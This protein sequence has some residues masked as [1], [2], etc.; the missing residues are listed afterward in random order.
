MTTRRVATIA[1]AVTPRYK[2]PRWPSGGGP[3]WGQQPRRRTEQ[4]APARGRT[5]HSSLRPQASHA[6]SGNWQKA[7]QRGNWTRAKNVADRV[8]CRRVPFCR[9]PVKQPVSGRLKIEIVHESGTARRRSYHDYRWTVHDGNF[10]GEP[11]CPGAFTP[12]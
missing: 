4:R 12:R 1:A 10:T 3:A 11:R 8:V 6:G 9:Y 5:A 2:S 7:W